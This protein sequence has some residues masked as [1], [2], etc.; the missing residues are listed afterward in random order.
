MDCKTARKYLHL[1]KKDEL[2]DNEKTLLRIHLSECKECRALSR[3]LSI[4]EDAIKEIAG[5]EPFLSKPDELTDR[6]MTGINSKKKIM[7]ENRTRILRRPGLRIAASLLIILQTGVFSYQHFYITKSVRELKL[8]TQVQNVQSVNPGSFNKEC[9]QET[10][11]I[12]T[13]ILGYEEPEL[14]RKAIRY[15]RKFSNEEIE[16]YA[17]QI[18][19]YSYTLQKTKNKSQ[20]KQLLINILSNDLNIKINPEI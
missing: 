15:G 14:Q 19:E 2:D 18:C 17:V 10:R 8:L 4:F 11:E 5:Q 1:F 6:I 20:K 13:D 12:I 16:N 9:I 7:P 3:E